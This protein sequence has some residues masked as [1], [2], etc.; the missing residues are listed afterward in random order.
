[1][2]R[3]RVAYGARPSSRSA[4]ASIT[5]SAD[6]VS[7]SPFAPPPIDVSAPRRAVRCLMLPPEASPTVLRLLIIHSIFLKICR[8]G[9][10]NA[11][12]EHAPSC[13]PLITSFVQVHVAAIVG[14]IVHVA[15]H[16]RVGSSH[17]VWHLGAFQLTTP[18]RRYCRPLRDARPHR[19]RL[20]LDHVAPPAKSGIEK[21]RVGRTS[22]SRVQRGSAAIVGRGRPSQTS[23]VLTR[24]RN[25]RSDRV[26]CNSRNQRN[27]HNRRKRRK[28]R[29]SRNRCRA[30]EESPTPLRDERRSR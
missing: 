14:I 22:Q 10:A 7:P 4:T 30:H 5:S 9:D 21:R 16:R 8:Q 13:S 17:L 2:R 27:Q 23:V 3:T 19:C 29:N 26:R 11:R 24:G 1:M 25:L 28:R 18:R 20:H 15:G 6:G 12:D